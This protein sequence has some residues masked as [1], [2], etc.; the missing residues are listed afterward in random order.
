MKNR[1]RLN[2]QEVI[3]DG[4]LQGE[5]KSTNLDLNIDL[6]NALAQFSPIQQ[7]VLRRVLI[8]GYSMADATKHTKKSRSEWQRWFQFVAMPA[9]QE[10]LKDYYKDGKLILDSE[11]VAVQTI[12]EPTVDD[13]ETFKCKFKDCPYV[14]SVFTR[15][16]THV[17]DA[18]PEYFS[19]VR[20]AMYDEEKLYSAERVAAEGMRG[21][22]ERKDASYRGRS[23]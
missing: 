5:T 8:E 9:L 12:E 16:R 19:Q 11:P 3:L 23:Y 14:T 20:L 21:Y 15:L 2:K 6:Q 17:K 4:D 1:L 18:H 10:S 7:R 13:T 22:A